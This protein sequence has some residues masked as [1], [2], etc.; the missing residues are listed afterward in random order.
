M[1]RIL[2]TACLAAACAAAIVAT[3][4]P[5]SADDK[6]PV[7]YTGCLRAD[8][9]KYVL[10]DLTDVVGA[11]TRRSWK[12]A[13]IVKSA[14]AIEVVGATPTLKLT[15]HVGRQVSVTGTLDDRTHVKVR[16]VKRVAA[17]CS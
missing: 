15:E 3:G 17:S 13:F 12:T 4:S 5:A 11:P 14:R 6:R 10:T 1:R 16:S 2:M 7:T 8:G 9:S